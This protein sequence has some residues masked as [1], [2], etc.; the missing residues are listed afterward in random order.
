MSDSLVS[1]FLH[2]KEIWSNKLNKTFVAIRCTSCKVVQK[3]ILIH[4]LFQTS[5]IQKFQNTGFLGIF[6]RVLIAFVCYQFC[7]L[8][9]EVKLFTVNIQNTI[10][11]F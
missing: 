10:N 2:L 7:F 11:T 3:S 8:L 9:E 5:W 4:N 6:L 1:E